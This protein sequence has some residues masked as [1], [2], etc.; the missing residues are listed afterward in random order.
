MLAERLYRI[1]GAGIYR[2]SVKLGVDVPIR[3]PS[4]NG[5]VIGQDS[6]LTTVFG[7]RIFWVWGDTTPL[8]H[9]LGNFGVTGAWSD[10]PTSGGLAV[11]RG[12]DLEY[13][14]GEGKG[15]FVKSLVPGQPGDESNVYWLSCLMTVPDSSGRERMLGWVSNVDG[16]S[17]ETLNR[18]IMEFDRV[19]EE[20]VAV[21]DWP[22][23]AAVQPGGHGVRVRLPEDLD[24]LGGGV[25]RPDEAD[26]GFE[27]YY[28]F[29]SYD[30]QVRVR[31]TYEAAKDPGQYTTVSLKMRP[32]DV[33]TGRTIKLHGCSIGWNDFR[34][35]WTMIASE[36]GGSSMLGELYYLEAPTPM[37][38]WEGAV[39]VVTHDN[40]TIYN[41]L[42]HPELAEEGSPYLYFEGTYTKMFSGNEVGTPWYDYNQIMYRLD[43]RDERLHQ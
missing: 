3:E 22:A 8:R 42:Q 37:G 1:T 25:L 2:D 23:S 17:M 27:D 41:P 29:T 20:F 40:Y 15:D 24:S 7:G 10:L 11:E 9:P 16:A 33:E 18:R 13:I 35:C 12:V 32:F 30:E 36:I 26:G 39:K 43:L 6:A 38:P 34:G 19:R 4:L 5:G 28:V 21:A 31:A 14:M